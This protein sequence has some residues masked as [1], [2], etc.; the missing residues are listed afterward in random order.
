MAVPGGN[1]SAVGRQFQQTPRGINSSNNFRGRILEFK[2]LRYS[3]VVTSID[4]LR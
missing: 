1:I 2:V 3:V 4:Q